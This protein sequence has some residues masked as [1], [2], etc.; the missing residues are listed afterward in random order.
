M[1]NGKN[2]TNNGYIGYD[3]SNST[4][5]GIVGSNKL[6]NTNLRNN[7]YFDNRANPLG[8]IGPNY[9]RPSAWRTLPSVTAGSQVI[10]GTSAVYNN[11]N[12]FHAFYIAGAYTV[13]WGDGTSQS[14]AAYTVASK[15]YTTATYAGL[16]SDVYQGYKTLTVTI[17]PQAG[18]NLTLIQLN[19]LHPQAGLYPYYSTP[20]LD[21]RMSAPFLTQFQISDGYGFNSRPG[22][23]KLEQLEFIGTAPLTSFSVIGCTNLQK[24]VAFP[25]GRFQ[26]YWQSIF[27]T[28][29]RLQE[30][31]ATM[32][33]NTNN[34]VGTLAY[35][36][37]AC[38][39]LRYVP[40]SFYSKNVNA[41][42]GMFQSCA[43]LRTVPNIDTSNCTNTNTMFSGCK[44]LE[45][46]PPLNLSKTT[47]MAYTFADCASLKT[48]PSFIGGVA[49][50]SCAAFNS[51]FQNCNSLTS[52]PYLNTANGTN[53]QYM[54]YGTNSITIPQYDYTKATTLF[55]MFRY[56]NI[57][58]VPDFNT[59]TQLTNTSYMFDGCQTIQYCPGITMS[60][61][62]D[63]S[64]MFQSC[65]SLQIIPELNWSSVTTAPGVFYNASAISFIGITGMGTSFSVANTAL[66]ATALNYLYSSLKTVGVSGAGA[67]T[68]TVTNCYGSGRGDNKSIAIGKGWTVTG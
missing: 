25:S 10:Y 39:S 35:L 2:R 57:Q 23:K 40:S 32:L 47:D 68:L 51:T 3:I 27:H 48:I 9:Q 56:S 17:T 66:G 67:R 30:I 12:N 55:G 61:V 22:S 58:Y 46:I 4:Q 36:F 6:Y 34:T 28:C 13:D 31:P 20:W 44:M 59:T 29:Y 15:Q 37:Y 65:G 16:T 45:E 60:A 11:D 42:T 33:E 8:V 53:F 49:G 43:N 41:T 63:V 18:S 21:I 5:E 64:Y 62:T 26:T 14:Y 19:N 50:A 38:S 1:K 52:F 54:F 7:I 24:I